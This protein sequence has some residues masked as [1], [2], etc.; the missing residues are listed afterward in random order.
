MT[1]L[2]S[3]D[4]AAPPGSAFS[5]AAKPE[6]QTTARH[7]ARRHDA[8]TPRTLATVTAPHIEDTRRGH[9]LDGARAATLGRQFGWTI[10]RT[11]ASSRHLA[12]NALPM[13]RS[14]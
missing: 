12:S 4:A 14:G 9:H 1:A 5:L 10:T 7:K 3:D 2:L 13:S 11:T 6:R 8:T